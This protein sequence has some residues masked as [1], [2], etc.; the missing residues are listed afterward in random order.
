MDIFKILG[1]KKIKKEKAKI[2]YRQD[3]KLFFKGFFVCP[4]HGGNLYA[5][6]NE[7]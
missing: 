6:V 2:L 7:H 4:T 1:E 5:L 3:L